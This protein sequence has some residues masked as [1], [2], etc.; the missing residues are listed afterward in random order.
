[1]SNPQFIP[2]AHLPDQTFPPQPE[3]PRPYA[4]KYQNWQIA[5]GA[6]PRTK[7]RLDL[8]AVLAVVI[9]GLLGVFNL[10]IFSMAREAAL[11][12]TQ[13]VLVN[14]Y[15]LIQVAVDALLAGLA[16]GF[17][18]RP[19]KDSLSARPNSNPLNLILALIGGLAALAFS[20]I[21]IVNNII[22]LTAV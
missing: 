2:P 13:T 11:D 15:V 1:M 9:A 17:A 6:P 21:P 3:G 7:P 5:P 4:D 10:V 19:I 8:F 20:V 14:R 12:W 22:S 16:I 18:I